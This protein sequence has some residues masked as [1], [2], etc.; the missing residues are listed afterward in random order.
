MIGAELGKLKNPIIVEGHTDSRPLSRG[1]NY[2]NW[3]LSTDRANAARKAMEEH[4]LA[5]S[6]VLAVRGYADRKLL[7]PDD[8][9][10]FSNRRV[11]ILVAYTKKGL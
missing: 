9:L 7:R 10:H 6:Q 2:S 1:Y 5:P 4:G 8:P 3:E 11:S